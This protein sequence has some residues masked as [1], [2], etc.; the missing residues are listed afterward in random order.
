MQMDSRVQDT[1]AKSVTKF[2][3]VEVG[4]KD[5]V[6]PNFNNP[7][8]CRKYLVRHYDVAETKSLN[9]YLSLVRD[10]ELRFLHYVDRG[11]N[12]IGTKEDK[13][14]TY[15]DKERAIV[16]SQDPQVS[17]GEKLLAA[18]WLYTALI[19]RALKTAR[20]HISERIENGDTNKNKAA[21]EKLEVSIFGNMH[22]EEDPKK[23]VAGDYIEALGLTTPLRKRGYVDIDDTI[24]EMIGEPFKLFMASKQFNPE[25]S[26]EDNLPALNALQEFYDARYTK[27]ADAMKSIDDA[28]LA[29]S[30]VTR[31][32]KEFK[33]PMN[34][35]VRT[36]KEK[37]QLQHG[38]Q[39]YEAADRHYMIARNQVQEMIT[40]R[41]LGLSKE[42]GQ[43][44]APTRRAPE[45]RALETLQA[46]KDLIYDIAV[47]H[48]KR[49]KSLALL[50]NK[51]LAAGF[52]PD[53][54]GQIRR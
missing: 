54:A 27:I 4:G 45:F 28:A 3:I 15:I 52:A 8:L 5:Y 30:G 34:I 51:A 46:A 43:D 21:L 9:P 24:G 48:E 23:Q 41:E 49:D 6:D 32:Y 17:E 38:D 25:A 35:L 26:R 13:L 19:G 18:R 2:P 44:N 14:N 12:I 39:D 31:R 40:A 20:K 37:I 50:E 47:T 42:I 36:T 53:K 22:Q 16:N 33:V 7:T 10:F 29:V 1:E 11:Y